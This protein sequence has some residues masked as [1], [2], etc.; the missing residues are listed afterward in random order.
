MQTGYHNVVVNNGHQHSLPTK[1]TIFEFHSKTKHK[2]QQSKPAKLSAL[3][4]DKARSV[5]GNISQETKKLKPTSKPAIGVEPFDVR[6]FFAFELLED[7][8][9]VEDGVCFFLVAA[10]V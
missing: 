9:D 1:K 6:R 2:N 4:G 5:S 10:T 3:S 7:D 8:E